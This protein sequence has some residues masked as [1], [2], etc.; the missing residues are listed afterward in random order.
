[1]RD[2]RW[3]IWSLNSKHFIVINVWLTTCFECSSRPLE[4]N[5]A[6]LPLTWCS[7]WCTDAIGVNN[8]GKRFEG[9]NSR[10]TDAVRSLVLALAWRHESWISVIYAS[11]RPTWSMTRLT[12][13]CLGV[14]YIAKQLRH[15]VL[16]NNTDIFEVIE[17]NSKISV[18]W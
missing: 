16:W 15:S 17:I 7:Y 3:G 2:E 18:A 9:S 11:Y 14:I 4:N 8:F 10:R 1:M 6:N 5:L 13:S 12:A